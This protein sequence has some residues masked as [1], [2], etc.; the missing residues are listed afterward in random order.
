[1][2]DIKQ[3][4]LDVAQGLIQTNGYNGFSYR[5]IAD[6]V[7]IQLPPQIADSREC[8]QKESLVD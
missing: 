2:N 5:D 6:Q 1:M 7:G 8:Q 4:L 3:Q